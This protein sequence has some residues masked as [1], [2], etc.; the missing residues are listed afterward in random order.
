MILKLVVLSLLQAQHISVF[1]YNIHVMHI[2]GFIG[3]YNIGE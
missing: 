1:M 3:N 2:V